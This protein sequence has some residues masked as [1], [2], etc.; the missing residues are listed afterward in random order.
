MTLTIRLVFFLGILWLSSTAE[1]NPPKI[2]SNR[3]SILAKS[4][5]V[6]FLVSGISW[7]GGMLFWFFE[8][9]VGDFGNQIVTFPAMVGSCSLFVSI[10]IWLIIR[11]WVPSEMYGIVLALPFILNLAL[12]PAI[13]SATDFF[14]QY[15]LGLLFFLVCGGLFSGIKERLAIAPIPRFLAGWPIQLTALFL[16]FLSLSFFHG[17]FFETIF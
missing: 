10:I 6:V 9:M 17:V 14:Y 7:L 3:P 12:L 15:N 11:R 5:A 13:F 4:L 2:G 1:K 16:I 8:Y